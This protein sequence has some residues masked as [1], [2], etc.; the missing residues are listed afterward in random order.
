M[1]IPYAEVIGDPIAQSKSPLIHGFWLERLGLEG[2]YRPL[3]VEGSALAGYFESRRA[4]PDWR[5]CNVTIPHKQAVRALL[6]H[7]EDSGVGAVNCV[8]GIQGRLIGRNTD[9]AGI[10]EAFRTAVAI[11]APTCLIG[12]GGAARAVIASLNML[13]VHDWNLIVRDSGGGRA[14]LA[15]FGVQG[16]TFPFE[17][18]AT[19]LAGAAG[20]VNATPLGMAGFP[21]MPDAVL[22]GLGTMRRGAF[23]LDLVYAPARTGFFKAAEAAGVEAIDGLTVLLGQAAQAFFH[24]FGAA[25]PRGHDSELRGLLTS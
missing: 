22:E 13:A 1:G 16:R 12:A 4:D 25:P 8:L 9:T 2:D 3:R 11:D 17:D 14:L 15:D 5:G 6:D 24:F 7:V 21:P 20:A 23:A 19:A 18:A 10:D